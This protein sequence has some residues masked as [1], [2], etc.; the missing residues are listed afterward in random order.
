MAVGLASPLLRLAVGNVVVGVGYWL[1][2][3]L[4]ALAQYTGAIEVAWLPV[5]FA[6][7][8]LYLGD[9]RW[10][11]GGMLGDFMV[12]NNFGVAFP[13]HPQDLVTTAGNTIEFALAAYLMRRW[14][15]RRNN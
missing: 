10:F 3:Q 5:G 2:A 7:G 14:L 11:V 1:L 6:A 13:F 15:G 9:L 12:G 8:V 4:G